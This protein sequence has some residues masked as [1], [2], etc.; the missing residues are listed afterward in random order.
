MHAVVI[1]GLRLPPHPRVALCVLHRW[2]LRR[3]RRCPG[4]WSFEQVIRD[5]L[6]IGRPDNVALIC[7]RASCAP[8]SPRPRDGCAGSC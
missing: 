1:L 8:A 7:E 4:R 3:M 2:V 5:S 6:D